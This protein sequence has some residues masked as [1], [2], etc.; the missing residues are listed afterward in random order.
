M[1]YSG[2]LKHIENIFNIHRN[3]TEQ[4]DGRDAISLWYKYFDNKDKRAL[5]RLIRYNLQ[6]VLSLE[7]ISIKIYNIIM[8][9]F[10]VS[11]EMPMPEQP[12]LHMKIPS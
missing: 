8:N 7:L 6:D 10:P 5:Q 1:G 2:G 9:D 12:D 3:V 11:L 4:L